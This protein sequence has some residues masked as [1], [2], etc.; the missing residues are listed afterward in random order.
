MTHRNA[1][2]HRGCARRDQRAGTTSG[3][4]PTPPTADAGIAGSLGR[5]S[6][7]QEEGWSQ[8]RPTLS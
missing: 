8:T 1:E 4:E 5:D 2:L 7:I 6:S 3:R